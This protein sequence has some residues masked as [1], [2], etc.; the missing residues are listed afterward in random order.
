MHQGSICPPCAQDT[1]RWLDKNLLPWGATALDWSASQTEVVSFVFFQHWDVFRTITEVFILVPALVGL[2]G[3]LEMTLA[4]RLST[5]VSV[6]DP[7]R[8]VGRGV[9]SGR[10]QEILHLCNHTVYERCP[11]LLSRN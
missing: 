8:G 3:N 5:A 11:F 1:C 4:S 2:K 9:I 6:N 7:V 10:H